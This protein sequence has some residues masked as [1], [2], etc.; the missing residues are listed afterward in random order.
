MSSGRGGSSPSRDII[1]SLKELSG[2]NIERFRRRAHITQAA[3]A[4][5]VG[6]SVRWLREVESGNPSLSL[7]DHFVCAQILGIPFG[8]LLFPLLYLSRGMIFPLQLT[9]FDTTELEIRIVELIAD[10]NARL[11]RDVFAHPNYLRGKT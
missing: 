11:M 4:P 10:R 2:Q 1:A 8:H 3:F 6:L 5:E 9:L 7:D